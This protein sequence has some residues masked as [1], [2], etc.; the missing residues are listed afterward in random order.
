MDT[1]FSLQYQFVENII[2]FYNLMIMPN[3]CQELLMKYIIYTYFATEFTVLNY[4]YIVVYS[5]NVNVFSL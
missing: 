1:T 3:L 5:M 4:K 2:F